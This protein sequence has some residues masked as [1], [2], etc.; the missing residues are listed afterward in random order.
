VW[1]AKTSPNT[2]WYWKRILQI[3]DRVVACYNHNKWANSPNRQYTISNGYQWLMQTQIDFP[4]ARVIWERYNIPKQAFCIRRMCL[5]KLPACD[6]MMKWNHHVQNASC[7]LCHDNPGIYEHLFYQCQYSKTILQNVL[8]PMNIS[9]SILNQ[10]HIHIR[11][12]KLKKQRTKQK[13]LSLCILGLTHYIWQDRNTRIFQH[14][15]SVKLVESYKFNHYFS[16]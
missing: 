16:Y 11:W 14:Q 2:S 12:Q 4:L 1:G 10:A 9:G 7:V 15:E 5:G 3:Q 13:V 6:R 8:S